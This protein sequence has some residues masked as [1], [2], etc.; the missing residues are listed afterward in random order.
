M[1]WQTCDII[2]LIFIV[3]NGQIL[4]TESNHLVTLAVTTK[5]FW[6]I[7]PLARWHVMMMSRPP[8]SPDS[9]KFLE[10]FESPLQCWRQWSGSGLWKLMRLTTSTMMMMKKKCFLGLACFGDGRKWFCWKLV[11]SL[12]FK[13]VPKIFD[14][15]TWRRSTYQF[16]S[17]ENF[18]TNESTRNHD[19]THHK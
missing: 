7:G 19:N 10:V 8:A 11:K 16:W 15:N 17:I 14:N 5:T 18:S 12:F 6:I 9:W 4:K 2:G 13:I 3:A 1:L